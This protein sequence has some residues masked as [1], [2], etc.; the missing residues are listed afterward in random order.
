MLTPFSNYSF[1]KTDSKSTG[2]QPDVVFKR[3]MEDKRIA[4]FFIE[5]LTGESI[6]DMNLKPQEF[7]HMFD[8][9]S[10]ACLRRVFGGRK[11]NHIL[12]YAPPQSDEETANIVTRLQESY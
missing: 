12:P 10:T 5:T 4:R 7:T 9:Y 1:L 3:L 2:N 6:A 8:T 11:V